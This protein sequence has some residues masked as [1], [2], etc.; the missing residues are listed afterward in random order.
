MVDSVED[1]DETSD[2]EQML[3]PLDGLVLHGGA[4]VAPTSYG[5]EPLRPEWSGDELRDRYEI[6]L[7][8]AAARRRLPLLAIC[9][10]QQLLNVALGGTLYQDIETQVD[11]ALRHRCAERYESNDHRVE[12]APDSHLSEIYG[13]IREATINSVHHQAVRE[14]ADQLTVE[15]TS[16]EDGVIEA[17]RATGE[18]GWYAA[19]VQWHPEFQDPGDDTLLDP[20]PLLDDFI[21]AM[22][23]RAAG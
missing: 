15:A 5:E 7:V 20:W 14:P 10:G 19:G 2:I 21:A 13:G 16:P 22:R 23:D 3:D 4:D 17:V 18:S 9:R 11:G 6:A 1:F 8:E 12:I